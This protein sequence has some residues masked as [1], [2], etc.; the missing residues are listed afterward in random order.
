[1]IKTFLNISGYVFL[2]GCSCFSVCKFYNYPSHTGCLNLM[3]CFTMLKIISSF[4]QKFFFKF[5]SVLW[6]QCKYWNQITVQ[7]QSSYFL[8]IA[9]RISSPKIPKG[10]FPFFNSIFLSIPNFSLQPL[11][12]IQQYSCWL[13]LL[14]STS[15]CLSSSF[16]SLLVICCTSIY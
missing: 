9:C 3:C 2:A 15:V 1:M 14:S 16:W 13:G 5:F 11:S 8:C 12:P 6:L 7:S 4:L 10:E